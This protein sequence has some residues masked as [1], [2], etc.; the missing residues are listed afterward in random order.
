VNDTSVLREI[1]ITMFLLAF[2]RWVLVLLTG[3]SQLLRNCFRNGAVALRPGSLQ[4]N[5]GREAPQKWTS[6][7]RVFSESS[8]EAERLLREAY[9]QPTDP[10][11]IL[12]RTFRRLLGLPPTR[13]VLIPKSTTDPRARHSRR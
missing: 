5:S 2:V 11:G 13:P 6:M 4:A 9:A 7:D 12:V 10:V 1:A 8:P 3:T